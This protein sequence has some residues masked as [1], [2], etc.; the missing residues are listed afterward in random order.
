MPK[1]EYLVIDSDKGD[2]G[3][4][5]QRELNSY[6]DMGWELVSVCVLVDPENGR[7]NHQAYFKRRK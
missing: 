1:W 4:Y 2:T 6:G 5:W 3:M 7:P